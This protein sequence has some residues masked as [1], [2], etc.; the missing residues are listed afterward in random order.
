[1]KFSPRY[2]TTVTNGLFMSSRDD[3]LT[4]KLWDEPFI[5]IGPERSNNWVYGDGYQSMGLIETPADDSTASPVL[6][7]YAGEGHWKDSPIL[8]RYTIRI[9]G[10]VS[11]YGKQTAGEFVTKPLIFSGKSLSLN[12]STSAAGSILVEL[13]DIN[14]NPFP[15]FSFSDCDELFGD[16]IDRTVTWCDNSS[17]SSLEGKQILVRMRLSEADLFSLK[18]K[19]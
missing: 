19:E 12:F 9:D 1:M 18:F 5:P 15:G 6:S 16:T 13:E 17:V 2:G 3:G 7:F 8:R 11:L 14:G 4:F 10:F